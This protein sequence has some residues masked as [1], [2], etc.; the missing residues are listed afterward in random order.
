M[1][2]W[3][4]DHGFALWQFKLPG[5]FGC[6][7]ATADGLGDAVRFEALQR[8]DHESATLAGRAGL[9]R[10]ERRSL[11]VANAVVA[12]EGVRGAAILPNEACTLVD[13][14][15]ERDAECLCDLLVGID[16]GDRGC[17]VTGVPSAPTGFPV[18]GERD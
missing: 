11:H 18:G 9:G 6:W 12:R 8:K 5:F 14:R 3:K 16:L 15:P 1:V 17:L 10:Y 13:A 4:D 2:R 7:H